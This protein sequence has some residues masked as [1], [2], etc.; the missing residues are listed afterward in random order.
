[1]II[2]EMEKGQIGAEFGWLWRAEKKNE[3]D[4]A[5]FNKPCLSLGTLNKP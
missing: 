2:M 1:M 4:S 3:H 5:V